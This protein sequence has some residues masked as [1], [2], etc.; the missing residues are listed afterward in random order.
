MSAMGDL[1]IGVAGGVVATFLMWFAGSIFNKMVLPWYRG[2][3]YK[4]IELAGTWRDIWDLEEENR[5]AE[6]NL[7]IKQIGHS[8][9]G[10]GRATSRPKGD[11]KNDRH[12]DLR[13]KGS[14]RDGFVMGEFRS[15]DKQRTIFLNVLL[16]VT[17]AGR[18]LE[19]KAN[20]RD[21]DLEVIR[22]IDVKWER[23]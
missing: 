3:V 1:L 19:G 4:G 10:S 17:N 14:V 20:Y 9:T 18:G 12:T 16:K 13:F 7:S 2:K 6:T 5:V 21:T 22:S 8:L 15:V 23:L 11:E